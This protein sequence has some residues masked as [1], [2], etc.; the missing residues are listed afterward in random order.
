MAINE[1]GDNHFARVV[2]DSNAFRNQ[3][4]P[5]F[6]GAEPFDLAVLD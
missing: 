4:P 3:V 2:T 1:T 6:P 5:V